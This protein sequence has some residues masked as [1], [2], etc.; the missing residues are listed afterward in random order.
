M[1]QTQTKFNL[2]NFDIADLLQCMIL[3]NYFNLLDYFL[4]GA[5]TVQNTDV[6]TRCASIIINPLNI[7]QTNRLEVLSKI[8]KIL[9]LIE[10]GQ[11][12]PFTLYVEL[13]NEQL[14]I[15]VKALQ[16]VAQ[17]S[18][19]PLYSNAVSVCQMFII[20]SNIGLEQ[21]AKIQEVEQIKECINA[22]KGYITVSIFQKTNKIN[23][24]FSNYDSTK[25]E[26]HYLG[27][28]LTDT[29]YLKQKL[30]GIKLEISGQS[31]E[32]QPLPNNLT[33]SCK[34]DQDTTK[35]L[36]NIYCRFALSLKG[37]TQ[38]F[39]SNQ[40]V[41]LEVGSSSAPLLSTRDFKALIATIKG[42]PN[43]DNISI[44]YAEQTFTAWSKLIE[45]ILQLQTIQAISIDYGNFD[46]QTAKCLGQK[47]HERRHD[48]KYSIQPGFLM[49]TNNQLTLKGLQEIYTT[50]LFI[51]KYDS[52]V[53]DQVEKL[54]ATY[55]QRADQDKYF[56]YGMPIVLNGLFYDQKEI[57]K[58]PYDL[59]QK[60]LVERLEHIEKVKIA[61]EKRTEDIKK[62][63]ECAYKHKDYQYMLERYRAL[64]FDLNEMDPSTYFKIGKSLYELKNY[65]E[66]LK[67][68]Y[69]GIDLCSKSIKSSGL[70]K[71]HNKDFVSCKEA[72]AAVYINAGKIFYHSG[73]YQESVNAYDQAIALNPNNTPKDIILEREMSFAALQLKQENA[74]MGDVQLQQI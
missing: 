29:N 8:L 34:I 54:Y 24:I 15:F 18:K 47:L 11:K 32:L 16:S 63:A 35:F 68:Y 40:L 36:N 19:N 7:P 26:F 60:F 72:S 2:P 20:T 4:S 22:I 12:K 52:L 49:I 31:K 25:L 33:Y 23:Q 5:I 10:D 17:S 55:M 62:D 51:V 73:Q 67:Y 6:S 14:E 71:E 48:G 37:N 50:S 1:Q 39:S 43:I 30:G 70:L 64:G 27:I 66:A 38:G 59:R 28:G 69:Y 3:T 57:F 42:S 44:R 56:K 41:G 65:S 46:D 13:Y 45:C 74:I 58:N 61:Q 53:N 9:F 21:G